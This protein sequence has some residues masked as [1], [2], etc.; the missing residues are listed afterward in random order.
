MEKE[1]FVKS[2]KLKKQSLSWSHFQNNRLL[3]LVTKFGNITLNYLGENNISVL[4]FKCTLNSH[5]SKQPTQFSITRASWPLIDCDSRI[6]PA[7]KWWH[8]WNWTPRVDIVTHMSSHLYMDWNTVE[9]GV[10]K[11][12]TIIISVEFKIQILVK[13]VSQF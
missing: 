3:L 1:T 7:I 5:K 10:P 13:W 2:S 6:V 8:Q 11:I 12:N 9:I 4:K